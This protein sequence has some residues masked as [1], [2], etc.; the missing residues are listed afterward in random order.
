MNLE[1]IQRKLIEVARSSP[2]S[3]RVP[4]AFERRIMAALA[5][6]AEVDPWLALSR[7]LWRAAVPAVGIMC[8]MS[9]WALLAGDPSLIT[10]DNLAADLESSVLAPLDQLEEVW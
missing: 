8:M 6:S 7:A 4:L 3:D 1:K 9:L 2:P 10:S 5:T